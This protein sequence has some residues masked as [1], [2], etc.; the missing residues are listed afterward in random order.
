MNYDTGNGKVDLAQFD[1]EYASIPLEIHEFDEVPQG[2]YQVN[3][4]KVELANAISSG[5]PMLKWTLRILGPTCVG[6]LLRRNSVVAS[7]D[8]QKWLKADLHTCGI[9]IEKL[10]ELH[11]RLGDLL[12]VKLEIT[13]R[14]KGD[15]QNIFFNRRIVID[16][17]E[18]RDDNSLAPF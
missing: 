2:S 5:N 7:R 14:I 11:D 17:L 9:D 18:S 15:N 3:V 8:N 16:N 12:D 13:T 1:E 10:S 6:R 4:E